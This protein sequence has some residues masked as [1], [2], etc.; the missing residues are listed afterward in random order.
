VRFQNRIDAGRLLARSLGSWRGGKGLLVLGIPRGGV[1]VAAEVARL[2]DAPLD[3]CVAHKIGAPGNPEFAIG[4]IAAGGEVILNDEVVRSGRI[5]DS[6]I[7]GEVAA[8]Q[9]ELERR[10]QT[11]RADS[12]AQP[13]E[14]RIVLLIDDGLATGSTAISA[15]AA[16]RKMKPAR[17]ILAVPVAPA[18][19]RPKLN[20]IADEVLIL[21]EPEIFRAVGEFF[22]EFDQ[23]ND[24]QV[25]TLLRGARQRIESWP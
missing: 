11:Y 1:V 4:S 2:L 24:E 22:D 15:C 17:L 9:I 12:I 23:V 20:L 5:P 8:Q 13:I 25:V 6:F 14:H 19:L 18:D 10:I 21:H 3:V 16:I 7:N